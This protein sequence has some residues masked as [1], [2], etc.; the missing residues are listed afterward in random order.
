MGG[1]SERRSRSVQSRNVSRGKRV[2]EFRRVARSGLV[3]EGVNLAVRVI[4][5][6]FDF[7]DTVL[8]LDQPLDVIYQGRCPGLCVEAELV[9]D[10]VGDSGRL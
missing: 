7:G 6:A 5:I 1:K 4:E 10:C 9:H 2:V 3:Q 8:A